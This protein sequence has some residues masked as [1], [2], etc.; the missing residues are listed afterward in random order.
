[1]VTSKEIG[2][3]FKEK[4][5]ALGVSV[6]DASTQSRIHSNVIADIENGVFDRLDK[7][8][9]KSF[10]K[11][12][13]AF[14]GID[15]K[16]VIEQYNKISCALP[17]KEFT[18]VIEKEEKRTPVTLPTLPP[19][20]K[21]QLQKILIAASSVVLVMLMFVLIGTMKS[22]ISLARQRRAETLPKKV[23]VQPKPRKEVAPAPK[24]EEAKKTSALQEKPA[25]NFAGGM[26]APAKEGAI[27][28]TLRSRGDAWVRVSHD[29]D[30]LYD[31]TLH[32][33]DSKT[34]KAEGTIRVWTGKAERLDFIVNDHKVSKVAIGVVKD[35]KVSSDGVKIGDDWAARF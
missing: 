29:G 19:I 8:Y 5:K 26:K 9:I 30:V 34:W 10:L 25:S 7:L 14:L 27:T 4:R 6:E 22:K 24:I 3:K 31:G 13:A 15:E 20:S 23:A 17:E 35:I 16:S 1:M 18:F 33:G 21:E 32:D 28:F 12:Y 2:N 11:K